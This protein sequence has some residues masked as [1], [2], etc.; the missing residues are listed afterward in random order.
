VSQYNVYAWNLNNEYELLNMRTKTVRKNRYAEECIYTHILGESYVI[1]KAA[2]G[3]IVLDHSNNLVYTVAGPNETPLCIETLSKDSLATVDDSNH[4]KIHSVKN[5]V[6]AVIHIANDD[7]VTTIMLL[8]QGILL[9]QTSKHI[10]LYNLNNQQYISTMDFSGTI[11]RLKNSLVCL[12]SFDRIALY[13]P[14]RGVIA[15]CVIS[16][17]VSKTVKQLS[18]K[19]EIFFMTD[20]RCVK[21]DWR[22]DSRALLACSTRISGE[23][24]RVII[25][26]P[27]TVL[28]MYRFRI[29]SAGASVFDLYK[30][31]IG[32]AAMGC[33]LFKANTMHRDIF[34][35]EWQD[36]QY[37]W[38]ATWDGRASILERG[39][40]SDCT[41]TW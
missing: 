12:V 21:W 7:Q 23:I 3:T 26:D 32:F 25:L 8:E 28:I 15:K 30:V 24:H 39:T 16:G 10:L 34:E 18:D 13:H 1:A 27:N 38:K 31:T 33:A 4:V 29:G 17:V 6:T 36:S 9:L 19:E 2:E 22:N 5:G 11:V 20:E 40:F 35:I 37:I 41:I 14:S